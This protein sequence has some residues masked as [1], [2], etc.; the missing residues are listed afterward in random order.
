VLQFSIIW[1][2]ELSQ[3]LM[4]WMVFLGA[5]LA[6]RQGRHVAVEMLQDVLPGPVGRLMRWTVVVASAGFLLAL[7]ILGA[8][9]AAFGAA[10]LTP[11]TQIPA[12]IPYSAVPVGAALFL[13]HLIMVA[14]AFVAKSFEDIGSLD[15]GEDA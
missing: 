6:F 4:V 13:F 8:R 2:E 9:Y 1:A 10:Q 12:S 3:Y 15:A 14:P 7:T 11:A 5:G